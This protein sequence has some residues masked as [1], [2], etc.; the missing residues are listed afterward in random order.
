MQGVQIPSPTLQ[1]RGERKRE[2]D[3]LMEGASM[4]SKEKNIG[5]RKKI[6]KSRERRSSMRDQAMRD[7]A[8]IKKKLSRRAKEESRGTLWKRRPSPGVEAHLQAPLIVGPGLKVL[9]FAK[10]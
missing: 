10:C 7:I 9:D 3:S 8:K 6:K 5:R 2:I 1:E 4:P